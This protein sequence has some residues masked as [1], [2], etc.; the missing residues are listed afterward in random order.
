MTETTKLVV[1]SGQLS[2]Q[3][4]E[5]AAD[6][7]VGRQNADL[8]LPD[9]EVSRRHALVRPVAGGVEIE[10]LGSANGTYVNGS[11]I[12]KPR[13]LAPGDLIQVGQSHLQVEIG[14]E[15]RERTM[16]SAS[17]AAPVPLQPA[18]PGA[19]GPAPTLPPFSPPSATQRR[20]A[21]S[22]RLGATIVTFGAIGLTAVA[23][24]LYFGLR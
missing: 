13:M 18:P 20:H 23:L 12:E 6:L 4:L 10:D 21:K 22:R 17:P 2:G 24:L 14:E 8:N 16:I 15:S 1:R 9:F 7:V 19:A 5:V 3:S 11:R